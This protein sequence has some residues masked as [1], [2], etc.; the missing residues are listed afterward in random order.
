MNVYSENGNMEVVKFL[1][2]Q[3]SNLSAKDKSEWTP[4]QYVE[5]AEQ[6]CIGDSIAIL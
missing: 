2:S 4:L 6:D 5:D 3:G 1:V